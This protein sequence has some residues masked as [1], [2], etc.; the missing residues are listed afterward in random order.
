MIS[1]AIQV[2]AISHYSIWLKFDDNTEGVVDLSHL[3]DKP[4]FQN[5]K[6]ADF[7]NKVFI[8]EETGAIAWNENIELCPDNMY[9]KIKGITFEQWKNSQYS[10]ASSK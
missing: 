9:L 7:F 6:E 3:I 1:N 2:K 5:W 4:V 10:Y 8:D